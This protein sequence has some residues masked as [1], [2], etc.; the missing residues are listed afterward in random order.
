MRKLVLFFAGLICLVA[1]AVAD[2]ANTFGASYVYE[3]GKRDAISV[4][5]YSL[6]QRP[7]TETRSLTLDLHGGTLAGVATG[8]GDPYAG[9]FASL[10]A[11]HK[12]TR[13]YAEIGLAQAGVTPWGGRL[14]LYGGIGVPF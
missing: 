3:I 5:S 10:R 9:F 12:T 14:S 11:T 13:V 2:E 1:P 7:V 4:V 8:G 6:W